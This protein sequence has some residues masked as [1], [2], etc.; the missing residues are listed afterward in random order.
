MIPIHHPILDRLGDMSRADLPL[1]SQ[2][3]DRTGD[4]EDAIVSPGAE[5]QLGH[6]H[7]QKLF[8]FGADVFAELTT[9][10]ISKYPSLIVQP[11]GASR[12]PW[13]LSRL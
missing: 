4:L 1:P 10:T 12:R 6:G 8:P 11:A 3:G 7:L 9:R 13:L 2:V 5:S